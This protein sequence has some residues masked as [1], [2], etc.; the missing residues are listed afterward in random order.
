MKVSGST[1]KENTTAE[2]S[3]TDKENLVAAGRILRSAKQS[4]EA[5]TENVTLSRTKS[6][7]SI[8]SKKI[9]FQDKAVQTARGEKI[10]IEVEDLT[11]TAGPSQNYWEV[12]AER[13]QIALDDAF[14]EIKT[15][16]DRIQEKQDEV[17]KLKEQSEKLKAEKLVQEEMLKESRALIAVLEDMIENDSNGI[18]HSLDDSMP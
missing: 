15:L 6:N 9:T 1:A 3:A 17:N 10:K 5:K 8:K 18:N 7:L 16:K 2:P 4:K 12:L 13:R 11:S 14:D